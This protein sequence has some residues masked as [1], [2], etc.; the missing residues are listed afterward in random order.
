MLLCLPLLG[1]EVV[2]QLAAKAEAGYVIPSP[3]TIGKVS[4]LSLGRLTYEMGRTVTWPQG[5]S[6]ATGDNPGKR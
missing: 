2:Q 3:L 5:C 6:K 4:A 1:D